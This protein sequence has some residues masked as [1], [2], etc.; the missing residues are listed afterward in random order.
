[1][2]SLGYFTVQ[3]SQ[4]QDADDPPG[5]ELLPD[6]I[7]KEETYFSCA[8]CHSI[9]LVA[10]QGMKR[11][12]WEEVFEWM[13]DEQEMEPLDDDLEKLVL[14]YLT[15]HFNIDRPNMPKPKAR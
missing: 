10:Q 7:G 3:A 11:Q 2:L 4:S 9:R 12:D 5:W 14:D 13:V 8:G 15:K 1:M 6:D